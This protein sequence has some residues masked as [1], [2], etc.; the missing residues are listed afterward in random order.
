[1]A[2]DEDKVMRERDVAQIWHCSP[3]KINMILFHD[4]GL[5]NSF[6]NA[7][8]C[9]ETLNCDTHFPNVEISKIFRKSSVPG[10]VFI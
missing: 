3:G 4:F 1:M 2:L 6:V 9:V 7:P 8:V 10:D 5:M